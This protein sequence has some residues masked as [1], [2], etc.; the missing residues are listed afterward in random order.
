MSI[1]PIPA[2][3]PVS[4]RYTERKPE[5]QTVP[6]TGSIESGEPVSYPVDQD[7]VKI[8]VDDANRALQILNT[9]L[10]FSIHEETKQIMV[11]VIDET[12]K[13]IIREI[14]PEKLLDA[15]AKMW[16]LVGI[17]VDEKA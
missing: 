7:S 14:P 12:N 15:L 16:E 5:P 9:R 2:A 1:S 13:E 8:A 11:K 6:K 10:Q 4:G 17:L 3:Q